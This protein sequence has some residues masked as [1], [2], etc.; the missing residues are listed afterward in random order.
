[1]KTTVTPGLVRRQLESLGRITTRDAVL[2]GTLSDEE[3]SVLAGLYPQWAAGIAVAVDGLYQFD[4]SLYKVAQAHTTQAD[5]TPPTVPALFT[6]VAAAGVIPEWVQPTGAQDA[7]AIGD[8]VTHDNPQDSG[9]IWVYESSIDANTTEPG[10]D[11]TFDRY[12]T[13]V[14]VVH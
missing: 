2:G 9:N 8:Q 5:W 13:P 4:G 14:E 3:V 6:P 1:M 10:R 12:W 11:G 7:Y